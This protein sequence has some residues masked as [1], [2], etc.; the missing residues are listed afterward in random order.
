VVHDGDVIYVVLNNRLKVRP[1]N[2]IRRFKDTIYVDHGVL[3]GD[4]IVSTPL[5]G[6]VNG[7]LVRIKQED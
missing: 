1:V 6:A 2:V 5:S 7:M 4:L 3:N